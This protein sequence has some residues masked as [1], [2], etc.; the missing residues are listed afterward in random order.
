M[1]HED[2]RQAVFGPVAELLGLEEDFDDVVSTTVQLR[3]ELGSYNPTDC[4]GAKLRR[5]S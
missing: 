2:G 5:V 3:W 4:F 1:T